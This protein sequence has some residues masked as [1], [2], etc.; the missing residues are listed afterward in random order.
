M[1]T[2][3]TA[4]VDLQAA[5]DHLRVAHDEFNDDI[6]RKIQ[7]ASA[8]V[9]K[10]QGLDEVPD[11]WFIESSPPLSPPVIQLPG[12][13]EAEVLLILSD[14]Y[15]KRESGTSDVVSKTVKDLTYL[16]GRTPTM[17]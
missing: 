8:I 14:L 4:L 6:Y 16:S 13:I 11:E 1:S 7:Q 10:L 17:S 9:L 12:D 2:H 5:K 3:T 15:E